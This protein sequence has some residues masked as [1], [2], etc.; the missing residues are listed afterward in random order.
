M[1]CKNQPALAC[2]IGNIGASARLMM[3]FSGFYE[4]H[5]PPP[6]GD[7]CGIVPQHRDGHRNSQK[8]GYILLH[9]FVDCLHGKAIR[10]K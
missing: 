2:P 8:R 7:V 5:E 3:A 4:S 1:K 10:S 9:H 6:S